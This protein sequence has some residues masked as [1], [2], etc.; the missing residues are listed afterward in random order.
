MP[1][2]LEF[3]KDGSFTILHLV[4]GPVT[5]LLRR[6]DDQ[7][8]VGLRQAVEEWLVDQHPTNLNH[9]VGHDQVRLHLVELEGSD[10][11]QITLGCFGFT[12]LQSR[13][14]LREA[15]AGLGQH[16]S[17]SIPQ[18]KSERRAIEA[19]SHT[20][21]LVCRAVSLMSSAEAPGRR[22]PSNFRFPFFST[23]GSRLL[24][25]VPVPDPH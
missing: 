18:S 25:E 5:C 16:R 22:F 24:S 11:R 4:V 19:S 15:S 9:V 10:L 1:F 8:L 7:T 14:E 13:V 17:P 3:D 12:R 20:R 6:L 23:C 21:R 2:A